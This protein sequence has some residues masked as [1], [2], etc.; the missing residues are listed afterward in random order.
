MSY[1]KYH[2]VWASTDL[3]SAA[4]LNHFESQWDEITTDADAHT[5]DT[6]YYTRTL[7]D[8]TFFSAGTL[9]LNSEY[10]ASLNS[11]LDS[12]TNYWLEYQDDPPF[13][14]GFDADLLDGNHFS[15]ILAAVMPIG[16]IMIWSGTDANVPSGW[17]ICDGG[18]YGGLTSPDLRD[19]FVI[20]AGGSYAVG[21]AI[22]P[23]T[24]NGT[25]TPTGSV[26][27]GVHT[28]STAELPA[29]THAYT[30]YLRAHT[31]D[32][33][34]GGYCYEQCVDG[35]YSYRTVTTD[36]MSSGDGSHGH[37]GSSLDFAG[38]DPRPPYHSLYY[39]IKYT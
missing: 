28:L 19:R 27:V 31:A 22:G 10:D 30:E 14:T 3:L 13:Y 1:T 20:G 16:A 35:Y 18:T 12:K 8:A 4:A 34:T 9:H 23:A 11:A 15:D 29:H 21:A 2:S 5:H 33:Y 25:I 32:A 39:I 6:R 36:T 17:H 7:A 38:I 26:T 24:W 37:S